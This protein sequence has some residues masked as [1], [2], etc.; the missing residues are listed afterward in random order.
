[1]LYLETKFAALLPFGVTSELLDEVLPLERKIS[2]AVIRQ[3]LHEVGQRM[4]EELGEERYL[5][6]RA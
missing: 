4:E 1:M 5:C 3:K 2:T 6:R